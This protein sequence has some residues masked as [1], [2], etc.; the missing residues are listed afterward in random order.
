MKKVMM[1]F[2]CLS[3]KIKKN[4]FNKNHVTINQN[5]NENYELHADKEA[6]LKNEYLSNYKATT[7]WQ[8][9]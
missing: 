6:V 4:F 8:T 2:A 5:C 1:F 7:R 3:L 9:L